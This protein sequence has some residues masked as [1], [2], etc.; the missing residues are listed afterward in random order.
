MAWVESLVSRSSRNPHRNG[1]H[2]FDP[3]QRI[4]ASRHQAHRERSGLRWRNWDSRLSAARDSS[5]DR[6]Y[7]RLG[8]A[9]LEAV[10]NVIEPAFKNF[11]GHI[12]QLFQ[13]E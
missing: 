12:V 4:Q 8:D 3:S 6:V 1:S 2:K 10:G 13:T 5:D 11:K 9:L 7:F